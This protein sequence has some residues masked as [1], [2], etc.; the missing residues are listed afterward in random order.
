MRSKAYESAL[1]FLGPL[2]FLCFNVLLFPVLGIL[3]QIR[4]DPN[5]VK[6]PNPIKPLDSDPDPKG[7]EGKFYT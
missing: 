6:D 2:I 1:I 4:K 7:S 5:V 3:T